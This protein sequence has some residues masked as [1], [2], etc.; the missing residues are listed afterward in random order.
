MA[1]NTQ[2]CSGRGAARRRPSSVLALLWLGIGIT[3]GCAATHSIRLPE[4]EDHSLAIGAAP[5]RARPA[6][7]DLSTEPAGREPPGAI[8][9]ARDEEEP[10]AVVARGRSP[11][12]DSLDP[13]A[14][15]SASSPEGPSQ[16]TPTSDRRPAK[17]DADP[18]ARAAPEEPPPG[19]PDEFRFAPSLGP[20]TAPLDDSGAGGTIRG[21]RPNADD[22]DTNLN[23]PRAER[24]GEGGAP[25]YVAEQEEE[26]FVKSDLLITLLGLQ[27]S[28]V[29]VFG[30]LDGSFTGN[31]ARPS[32]GINFGVYPN[33]KSNQLMFNQVYFVVENRVEQSD[34]VNFGF[35]VD[36]LFGT[37]WQISHPLGLFEHA[38]AVNGFGYDF[39]QAYA[40]V[41]LPVLTEGGID[42][43]G[44]RFYALAGYE[45][46]P[47]PSRP[48]LSTTYMF[49]FAQ[50]ITHIGL[51]SIWHATDQLNIYN[52]VVNGWDRWINVHN[53]PGYAGAFAWD[54]ASGRTNFT[55]TLNWGPNQLPYFLPANTPIVPVGVTPPP[56]LAGRRN[57]AYPHSDATLFTAVLIHE[58]RDW[59]FIAETNLGFENNVPGAG[60]GGTTQ[61][62]SWYGLA[63]WTLYELLEPLTA[64]GRIEV[65][66]DNN[67]IL[68]GYSDNFS[69]AT[70][71][72]IFRPRPWIW[73]RP[74]TR[75]DWAQ[76]THPYNGGRSNSQFTIGFDVIF[77][78]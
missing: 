41:H 28:P 64:V 73:F 70:L 18:P 46:L 27:E 72:L 36:N 33:N 59:T 68:T 51:M 58:W 19:F 15:A 43:K 77:L 29:K 75:F 38:F 2:G 5:A 52:G 1:T 66:R 63:G 39:P 71:G 42:I 3:S 49:S 23:R 60:R 9:L 50:P 37:D 44:G 11:A 40:E 35:R 30:W 8:R 78:F 21:S 4:A 47:A 20:G 67:G 48:L 56:Y 7:S 10:S 24:A 32:D 45:D 13:P 16:T 12:P 14:P 53:L 31:P 74:E 55:A 34:Q 26:D 62:A 61:N 65:F 25:T 6:E 22:E 57:P 69:D 17:D 54:S 76:F